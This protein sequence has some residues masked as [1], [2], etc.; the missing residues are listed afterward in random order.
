LW[1]RLDESQKNS[2]L[3]RFIDVGFWWYWMQRKW[4]KQF[5]TFL[6]HFVLDRLHQKKIILLK[7]STSQCLLFPPLQNACGNCPESW[8]AVWMWN[9]IQSKN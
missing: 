3:K 4:A 6:M 7:I 1:H 2:S 5:G 8:A 9:K